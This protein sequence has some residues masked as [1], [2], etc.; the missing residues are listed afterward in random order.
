MPIKVDVRARTYGSFVNLQHAWIL[1]KH[2]RLERH[3]AQKLQNPGVE[4]DISEGQEY[5]VHPVY[6]AVP[7]HPRPILIRKRDL[8]VNAAIIFIVVQWSFVEI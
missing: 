2:L 4:I 1:Y 8:R 6:I 3:Y 7:A 5:A